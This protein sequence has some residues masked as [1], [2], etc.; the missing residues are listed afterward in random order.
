[1]VSEKGGGRSI[2]AVVLVVKGK[3][4]KEC[5]RKGRVSHYIKNLVMIKQICNSVIHMYCS[6]VSCCAVIDDGN[7]YWG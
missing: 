6:F 7:D 5:K 1:M 3:G 4:G 2:P